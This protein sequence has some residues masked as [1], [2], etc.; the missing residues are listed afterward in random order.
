MNLD[1]NCGQSSRHEVAGFCEIDDGVPFSVVAAG[2]VSEAEVLS[3]N[4]VEECRVGTLKRRF[5]LVL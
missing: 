3:Q 2:G 4:A 5:H 1:L